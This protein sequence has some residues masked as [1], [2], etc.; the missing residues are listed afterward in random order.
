M[1]YKSREC[2]TNEKKKKKKK[3]AAGLRVALW[4]VRSV[5]VIDKLTALMSFNFS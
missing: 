2:V 5:R 3:E 4:R 1:S